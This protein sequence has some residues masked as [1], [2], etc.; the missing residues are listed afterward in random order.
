M[1]VDGSGQERRAAADGVPPIAESVRRYEAWLAA[2][3][4]GAVVAADLAAKH[5]RMREGAFPFLR[6]SYWR[7]AERAPTLL[8][9]LMTAPPILAIGDTHLENF[10]TWRDAEGRLVWGVNDFDEAAVM[11][12]P[13]DLVRL[14]VSALLGHGSGSAGP[15]C[16]AIWQGYAEGLA[17]PAPVILERDHGWLREA[18]LLPEKARAKWWA[19]LDRA[20][21]P[22]PPHYR[23]ALAAAMPEPG[24][25][26]AAFARTAGTGSL[27]RPRYAAL[28]LWRGAPVVRECKPI[29]P[30]AW[31]QFAEARTEPPRAAAIAGAATRAVDPHYRVADGLVVR[32]L[33]PN[34]RKV[35][36]GDA[37]DLLFSAPMLRLMGAEI[38]CCHA[39]DAAR[40]EAVRADVAGRDA[41]WLRAPVRAAA[42]AL[43]TDFEDF[44]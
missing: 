4:P 42:A 3:L 32:R 5:D 12:Y 40:L 38:A 31:T 33:S 20:D 25:A 28:A 35:E 44:A 13:L 16:K 6:A 10:G 34:S 39:G 36:V 11:P 21:E 19:R 7:W 17:A 29:L 18:I 2:Q 14:A 43:R 24:L 8:P 41:D 22:V 23:A 1:S 30:S 15:V 9:E 37:G 26:F 27:G